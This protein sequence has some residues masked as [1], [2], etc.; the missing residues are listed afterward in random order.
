M[1]MVRSP[2]LLAYA[3]PPLWRGMYTSGRKP[4]LGCVPHTII[5]P[6]R[7]HFAGGRLGRWLGAR[8]LGAP[9]CYGAGCALRSEL[10]LTERVW[11]HLP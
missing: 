11:S 10:R 9:K 1:Y 8:P 5:W 7:I 2:P 4:R 6:P 3:L